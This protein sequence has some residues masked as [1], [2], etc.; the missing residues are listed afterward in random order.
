MAKD[1]FGIFFLFIYYF[2]KKH[3]FL[4]ASISKVKKQFQELWTP[5]VGVLRW[6]TLSSASRKKINKTI[7]TKKEGFSLKGTAGQIGFC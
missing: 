5:Q 4:L 1:Y 2:F 3:F 6:L 7:H